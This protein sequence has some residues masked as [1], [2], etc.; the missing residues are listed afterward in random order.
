VSGTFDG[1]PDGSIMTS[2]LWQS[3]G[4]AIRVDY[5]GDGVVATVVAPPIPTYAEI[6]ATLPEG[7]RDADDDADGDGLPNLLDVL[8]GNDPASPDRS[9]VESV[10]ATDPDDGS[11]C[12]SVSFPLN[13]DVA[14]ALIALEYSQDMLL[15]DPIWDSASDPG[16]AD[17]EV[18][19]AETQPDGEFWVTIKFTPPDGGSRY[20]IRFVGTTP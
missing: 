4:F 14:D 15:W 17:Q 19:S 9:P 18:I 11:L 1:F 6:A 2:P 7:M 3:Q 13:L 12:V 10:L 8:F 5:P 20:F 16:F